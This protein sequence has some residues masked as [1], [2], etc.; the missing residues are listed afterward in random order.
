MFSYYFKFAY[1]EK[2]LKTQVEIFEIMVS[3][4]GHQNTLP[5]CE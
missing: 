3:Q 4:M 2:R 5:A 1:S